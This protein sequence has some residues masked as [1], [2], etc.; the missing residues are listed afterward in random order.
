MGRRSWLA[1]GGFC[2]FVVGL[3]VSVAV[4]VALMG[5]SVA[6]GSRHLYHQT[7]SVVNETGGELWIGSEIFAHVQGETPGTSIGLG[8]RAINFA[9]LAAGGEVT[10]SWSVTDESRFRGERPSVLVLESSLG[11]PESMMHGRRVISLYGVV[12]DA[13]PVHLPSRGTAPYRVRVS[14]GEG[15]ELSGVVEAWEPGG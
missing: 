3:L 5:A 14:R 2:G 4:V 15:G 8:G 9:A 12:V 13:E 10:I 7:V 6:G 1:V 11:Q